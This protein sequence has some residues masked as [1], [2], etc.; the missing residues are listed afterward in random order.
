MRS[1][2]KLP[3]R[4]AFLFLILGVGV[5]LGAYWYH[6]RIFPFPQLSRWKYHPTAASPSRIPI[7]H[8]TIQLNVRTF[9][10]AE[11][12]EVYDTERDSTYKYQRFEVDLRRSALVLIDVWAD[13]S[14]EGWIERARQHT[15]QKLL[16]LLKLARKNGM[17]VFHAPHRR[18]IATS[19]RPLEGEINLD[20]ARL[21][22]TESFHRFLH[23][24]GINTLL[25]AGYASNWCVLNRPVGIIRM[26]QLGYSIILIRDC[27]IAFETPETLDGEWANKVTINTIE[28]QWG[29]TTTLHD[30]EDAF[31]GQTR[32]RAEPVAD[33]AKL[34]SSR[35]DS[36]KEGWISE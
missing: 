36:R 6:L 15:T 16:P 20:H 29:M 5:V 9:R 19:M 24:M 27:T 35:W 2:K 7:N 4:I 34:N 13:H 31:G 28:T 17:T 33:R 23:N 11:D 10:A 12:P 21:A 30:L 26:S 14:N 8:K 25:Y 22:T 32:D 3:Y 18:A 1:M